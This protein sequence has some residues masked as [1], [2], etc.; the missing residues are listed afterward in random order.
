MPKKLE[1]VIDL[2]KD[3]LAMMFPEYQVLMIQHLWKSPDTIPV[4]LPPEATTRELFEAVNKILPK[5]ELGRHAA[6]RASIINTAK[7][8]ADKLGLWGYREES[9]QGGYR[10]LYHAAMTEN[11]RWRK[12]SELVNEKISGIILLNAQIK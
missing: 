5:T 7:R 4:S 1:L 3:G 11:E 8:F 9:C 12:I 10:R 6:S 2:A